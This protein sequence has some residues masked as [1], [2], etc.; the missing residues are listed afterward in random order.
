[1]R[2][3]SAFLL[4]YSYALQEKDLIASLEKVGAVFQYLFG[5]MG[6]LEGSGA[7]VESFEELFVQR[8]TGSRQLRRSRNG[9]ASSAGTS[10]TGTSRGPGSSSDQSDVEGSK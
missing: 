10:R 5:V 2:G 9:S 4:Y 8:H 6:D 3:T 1:M 7:G